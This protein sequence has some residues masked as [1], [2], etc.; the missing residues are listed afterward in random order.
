[1]RI[2][3]GDREKICVIGLGFVGLS[4]AV[5]LASRGNRVYGVDRDEKRC[6]MINE[7]R[8][9]IGE[10]DLLAGFE[11]SSTIKR[12]ADIYFICVPTPSD[13]H[14]IDVSPILQVCDE[15]R[16]K[17]KGEKENIVV[18][19]STV[20]PGTTKNLIAPRIKSDRLVVNPEFLQEGK[21]LRDM[22]NP[23]RIV[24]G[25]EI[26]EVG[27]RIQSL[28]DGPFIRTDWI[29]AELIKYASNAA[30]ATKLSFVNEMANLAK[31]VGADTKKVLDGVGMDP[32]FSPNYMEPGIGFGG[33]CLPKDLYALIRSC[34]EVGYDPKL[35]KSVYEV[36]EDQP[37]RL[38]DLLE[39]R[40]GDLKGKRIALLGL[41][42]KEGVEDVRGSRS[43]SIMD[44]LLK[45]GA[46][47]WVYDP[48]ESNVEPFR[49]RYGSKIRC[50][51][52]EEA[53]GCLVATPWKGVHLRS[54]V[55]TIFGRPY[56]GYERFEGL[57]W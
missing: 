55:P 30:L 25:S 41:G 15:L 13:E 45:R 19:R 39:K 5:Y 24:I 1:M 23:I 40:I 50:A 22:F 4:T 12:D 21:A 48:F 9:P 33:S 20:T 8:S 57:N 36:N 35:L 53:D 32:R 52:L 29:T 7:G 46:R 49:E 26:Q 56:P 47:V 27:D 44:E 28:Y 42:F 11:A 10:I 17:V 18:V 51:E 6:L 37:K 31:I 38:V 3:N 43:F 2:E 16:E 54:D 14:G 34:E